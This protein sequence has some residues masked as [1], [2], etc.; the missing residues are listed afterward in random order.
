MYG[1]IRFCRTD[2]F[3]NIWPNSLKTSYKFR[4][5]SIYDMF[6]KITITIINSIIAPSLGKKM[7]VYVYVNQLFFWWKITMLWINSGDSYHFV[8]LSL[9][10]TSKF[11][12]A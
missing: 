7:Y 8:F 1:S 10:N 3:Y 12:V 5:I 4:F 6:L 2:N 9:K 11:Y